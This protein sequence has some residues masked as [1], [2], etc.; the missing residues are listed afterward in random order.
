MPSYTPNNKIIQ[1]NILAA[2]V[3]A[4]SKRQRTQSKDFTVQAKGET[5]AGA[6]AATILIEASNV[7]TPGADDW[8][9]IDTLS[10]TLAT[11][12]SSDFGVFSTP[13]RWVRSR[14]TAVSGT[15]GSVD[16]WLASVGQ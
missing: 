7:D 2:A 4:A 13:Y 10:L 15:D 8:F 6:G 9:L 14:V 11:T 12:T 3:P 1:E 5:S 16:V